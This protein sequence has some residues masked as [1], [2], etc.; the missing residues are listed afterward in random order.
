M[1]VIQKIQELEEVASMSKHEQLVR[2]IENAIDDK[3]LVHGSMLPSVNVMVRELGFARKTIV[4]AY[5]ELKDRGIIESKNRLG[6]FVTNSATGQTIK[7]ALLLYAFHTFQEVFYNTFRKA[8]GDKVQID[9]FFHHNNF[10]VYENTL[11]N[12]IDKYGICVVAPI[13]KSKN[14]L[15]KIPPNKL[16][17]VDR[18]EDM[19]E[20]YSYIAQRFHE[21]TYQALMTLKDKILSFNE[22]SIFF[23]QNVD[24]PKGIL[25][26]FKQFGK[27]NNIRTSIESKYETGMVKAGSVYF[28]VGDTDLWELLKDCRKKG[29]EL[30]KDVGIL[31]H[32]DSPVKEIICGG[33]TTVST[34]FEIM[35]QKAAE[36]VISR[37]KV[38]EVIPSN[39][40]RRVSL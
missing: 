6:Y 39:L 16:L 7:V 21:P 28:T 12:I 15:R 29:L 25:S 13:P 14:L 24:Y 20:E 31:S 40:L 23:K 36:Y 34:N 22:F 2:G 11:N 1:S 3:M 33:I 38:R 10:E 8:V 5:S 9:V 17:I 30:G 35:G 32:N 19:G 26:A 4:K 37:E 27:E 18:L